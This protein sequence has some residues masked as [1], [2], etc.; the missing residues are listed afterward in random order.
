MIRSGQLPIPREEP[1]PVP[2]VAEP[3][4]ETR[5]LFTLLSVKW[6][7][8]TGK[9]QVSDQYTDI[10]LPLHLVGRALRKGACVS[11]DDDRRKQNLNAHGGRH[12][13]AEYAVD[14]DALSDASGAR[15]AAPNDPVLRNDAFTEIDR[16]AD[17]RV[18]QIAAGRAG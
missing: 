10:D 14:L 5:R 6:R 18:I 7:D 1:K 15:Y 8:E 3:A 17:A 11:I 16:S 13:S 4:P 2:V 12:P 9:L